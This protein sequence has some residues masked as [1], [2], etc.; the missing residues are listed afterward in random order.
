MI[1]IRTTDQ[2]GESYEKDFLI[3]VINVNEPPTDI[4]LSSTNIDENLEA[5]SEVGTL[6]TNDPDFFDSHTYTLTA[7]SGDNDNGS[8]NIS[9][10]SLRLTNPAD[11]ETKSSYSVRIKVT[12]PDG[13]AFEKDFTI[14]VNN[15]NEAPVI[16]SPAAASFAENGTG[17]VYM[18]SATDPEGNT[19]T[20]SISGADASLFSINSTSG[21]ITF[22]V[23]PNFEA[24]GDSNQD[25]VYHITLSAIDDGTGNL[26]ALL[27]LEITVTD[28]NEAPVITTNSTVSVTEGRTSAFTASANDP[29]GNDITWSITGGDDASLFS[30]VAETGVVTFT[31]APSF[32]TPADANLDNQYVLEITA[33]DGTHAVAK[34]ITVIVTRQV[35]DPSPSTPSPS[36]PSPSTPPS[37]N[38][39]V[40]VNGEPQSAG[41]I[42][43]QTT[44]GSTVT[45]IAVDDEKLNSI[46]ANTGNHATVTLQTSTASDA[47]I[48]ELSG[49]TIKNMENKQAILEIRTGTVTYTLPASQINIEAVSEQLGGQAEL[50]DVKVSVKISAPSE[51]TVRIIEDT[52]QTGNYAL[53]VRPVSF[54]I[55]CTSG[56]K[57]VEVSRFNGY[58]ERTIAIPDGVDPRKI[59]TGVVLE[60]DGS[61][62]HVPTEIIA[63]D[64]RYYA[65]IKSLTNSVYSVI[66]N[67]V[68]FSDLT[69]YGQTGAIINDLGSRLII[70]GVGNNR[71]D[72][73]RDITRAEFSAIIVK[74]L[75]LKPAT[76]KSSFSDVAVTARYTPYLQTAYEYGIISGYGN[77]RFGPD[78]KITREQA[79]TMLGNAMKITGLDTSFGSD[80]I[81]KILSAYTDSGE[82]VSWGRQNMAACIK[83]GIISGRG[84]MRLSP[85]ANITRAEAAIIVRNLLVK[86][87]LI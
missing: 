16:S 18:A 82:V 84:G 48:G 3:Y 5:N 27:N 28:I 81:D 75:G 69:G 40:E 29:E 41:Q 65:R 52:A 7:G 68:A 46:L 50:K 35:S 34:T 24:P 25:N 14:I 63:V 42:T 79:M 20:W 33:D 85:K 17:V 56:D 64:G 71:Y 57:T 15:V 73:E 21:E 58:I 32:N 86:S 55:T 51:E 38:A 59:T 43:T 1:R 61:F 23:P 39:V 12:D 8:F 80:E 26:T 72:P 78:D 60:P 4:Y 83:A 67:P 9:G 53:V 76:G 22:A 45:T 87:G 77:G 66:W 37:N 2:G 49:Q 70:S 30:I 36:A 74:A 11:Y 13:L 6:S 10:N 47:V 44:G 62:Y 19:I 54:E 31:S